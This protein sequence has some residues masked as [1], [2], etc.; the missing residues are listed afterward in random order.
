MLTRNEILD[1]EIDKEGII[2]LKKHNNSIKSSSIKIKS[3]KMI[4]YDENKFETSAEL[5]I[6]KKEELLH[7][8]H[9]VF[10]GMNAST[11]ERGRHEYKISKELTFNLLPLDVLHP[12]LKQKK[13]IWE[14]SEELNLPVNFIEKAIQIYRNKEM[15]TIEYKESDDFW[16]A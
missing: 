1:D 3:F 15:L 7:C 2:L 5:F 4:C 6:A 10:Y 14:I 16:L 13:K 9:D 8:K 11:L 12:F